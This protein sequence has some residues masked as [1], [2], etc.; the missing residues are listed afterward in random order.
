MIIRQAELCRRLVTDIAEHRV[1]LHEQDVDARSRVMPPCMKLP[2]H[3]SVMGISA[4]P[5]IYCDACGRLAEYI[6][7][8]L[9]NQG[10]A[11]GPTSFF[12]QT[13]VRFTCTSVIVAC[14]RLRCCPTRL[15]G[16][17]SQCAWIH[18]RLDIPGGQRVGT[19]FCQILG[20]GVEPMS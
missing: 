11:K 8:H 10:I 17:L 5:P 14:L 15:R 20:V 19:E 9:Q 6:D 16:V 13:I 1:C 7:L 4:M 2:A 18:N 3:V 12:A